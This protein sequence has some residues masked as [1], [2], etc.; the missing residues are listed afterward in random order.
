ML[1]W[2]V[3][4]TFLISLVAFIGA[5]ALFLREKILNKVLLIFVAFSAGALTGGAFL[6]L[7][8][9]A[10]LEIGADEMPLFTAEP[11]NAQ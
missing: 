5:L 11:G 9:E 3:A 10:I 2:I 6:H 7:I 8:P 1:A 4:A